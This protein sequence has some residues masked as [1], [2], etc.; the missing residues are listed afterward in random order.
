MSRPVAY[1]LCVH[2]QVS[3]RV[4]EC[5]DDDMIGKK[6]G[7]RGSGSVYQRY[8]GAWSIILGLGRLGSI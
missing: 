5:L 2:M 1:L 4:A 6:G 8:Y 3:P 7:T